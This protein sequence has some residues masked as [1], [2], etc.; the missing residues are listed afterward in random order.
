MKESRAVF[1]LTC[2]STLCAFSYVTYKILRIIV[3][4]FAKYGSIMIWGPLSY[5]ALI[6]CFACITAVVTLLVDYIKKG[7]EI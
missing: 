6:I 1:V 2:L 4:F 7:G 3:D 5:V